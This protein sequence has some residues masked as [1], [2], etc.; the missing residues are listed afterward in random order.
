MG[1][2][3]VPA[4]ATAILMP[5]QILQQIGMAL[6]DTDNIAW[7]PGCWSIDAAISF[8]VA[9]DLSD[10]FG[11]RWVLL[12]GQTIILVGAVSNQ[13]H[14]AIKKKDFWR[15]TKPFVDCLRLCSDH[16]EHRRRNYSG[17]LWCRRY[18][19]SLF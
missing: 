5:T 1:L 8:S 7:I 19:G 13:I 3:Y 17:G 2:T 15:L 4:I 16:F 14:N 18:H 11:R 10:V 12:S 9:G 6:G